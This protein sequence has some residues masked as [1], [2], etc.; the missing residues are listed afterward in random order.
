M[1]YF[2]PIEFRLPYLQGVGQLGSV[3]HIF[4]LAHRHG[5]IQAS[6]TAHAVN[7]VASG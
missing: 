7:Q 5:V 1:R 2:Q 4:I 6:I 3:P